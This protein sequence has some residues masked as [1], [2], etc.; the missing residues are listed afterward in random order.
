MSQL[1]Q[2]SYQ[3]LTC[4]KQ[5]KISK[6]DNAG[7]DSKKKKWD[8]FE[9]DGVTPHVCSTTNNKPEQQQQQPSNNSLKKEVAAIKAQ[10]LVLVSRLDHIERELQT[11]TC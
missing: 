10:L 9:L 7:P 3:C 4:Q 6:I 8:K 11:H 5:I 1:L 2:K